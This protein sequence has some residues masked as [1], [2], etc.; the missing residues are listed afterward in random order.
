MIFKQNPQFRCSLFCHILW[1]YNKKKLLTFQL[2][3]LVLFYLILTHT[4][5]GIDEWIDT[6]I[7]HRQPMSSEKEEVNV[8]MSGKVDLKC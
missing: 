8:V 1:G 7:A 4:K 6:T 3:E 2:N 5:Y